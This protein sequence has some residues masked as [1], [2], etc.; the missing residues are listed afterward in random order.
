VAYLVA[1]LLRALGW[2]PQKMA[3]EWNRVDL[4]LFDQLPRED[5]N[6]SVVVEAKKKDSSCLTALSQ[7]QQYAST[8]LSC[9]RLIV[10]DGLRFGVYR[11]TAEEFILHAYMNLTNLKQSYPVFDCGGVKD[12]LLAMT[13]EWSEI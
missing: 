11:K 7:A 3:I 9:R 10:T 12:A 2:T 13:P 1:P 5:K 4:A 6:L 8:R